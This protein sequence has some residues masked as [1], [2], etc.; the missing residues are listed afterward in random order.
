MPEHLLARFIIAMTSAFL[1]EG[2]LA[3]GR[4]RSR[5]GGL[6]GDFFDLPFAGATSRA[7]SATFGDSRWMADQIRATADFRSVNFLIGFSSWN[8][9][10][11]AEE[12][13]LRHDNEGIF[14]ASQYPAE[15]IRLDTHQD[16]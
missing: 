10:T 3:A 13:A 11:R 12:S 9:A 7:G 15:L 2:S 4:A 16:T 14:H 5:R 8:G 1:F 6:V